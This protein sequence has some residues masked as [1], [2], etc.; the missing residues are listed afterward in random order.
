M[1]KD[2]KNI[3]GDYKAFLDKVFQR[4]EEI[5]IDV[6]SFYIDHLCYRVETIEKYEELKNSLLGLGSQ[7]SENIINGRPISIFKLNQP[8]IYKNLVIPC[9][10]LPA[11]KPTIHYKEG[12]EHVEFVVDQSI[13]NFMKLYSGVEFILRDL[14][15]PNNSTIV[16][17]FE[18]C[19]IK[20]HEKGIEEVVEQEKRKLQKT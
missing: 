20:F 19:A 4:V 6:H 17:E 7:I 16:L 18:D 5:G 11:P 15:L 10:E 9:V 13:D 3:I 12:L 14:N 1:S 8:I 2:L